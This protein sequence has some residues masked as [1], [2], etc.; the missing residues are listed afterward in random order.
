MSLRRLLVAALSLAAL[1]GGALKAEERQ[2]FDPAQA[3]RAAELRDPEAATRAYLDAV[4]AERRAQTKSYAHGNYLLDLFDLGYLLLILGALLGLGVSARMRDWSRRL[5]RFRPLQTGAY[6]VQLLLTLTLLTFPPTLYRSYFREKAYGLLHQDLG[7]WLSDQAIALGIGSLLGALFVML[8]YAV[9]RRAPRTW[10]VWGAAVTVGFLIL[11]VAIG[12]VFIAPAFNKFTPVKDD[13]IRQG[14]LSLARTHGVPADEVYEMD[15]SRRSDR[16]S[17]YVSGML[18]TTRIVLFDSTLKRC[19]PAEIRM[20]MS[21]EMGHYV[22]NH[23]W[24]AIGFFAVVVL[25]GF[26]GIRWAFGWVSSRYPRMGIEGVGDLAG[27]P[28][29][30]LLLSLVFFVATPVTNA[31]SRWHEVEADEFG[32]QASREPDAAATTYLKLGEYRDLEPHP[33]IEALL[34]DHPSGRSR[35]RHAMEWKAAHLTAAQ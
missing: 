10:W 13:A 31:Y 11:T 20:I 12:P 33:L 26:G 18:G 14:V 30:W 35:I 3:Q 5:T 27:L 2:L 7:S 28:L 17:A 19:T 15:A 25:I 4:P 21:H 22:L 6:W 32:F 9:L 23:V 24:K 16:I 29:L 8:L 34:Y 1:S